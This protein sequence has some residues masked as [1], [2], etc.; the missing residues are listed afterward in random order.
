MND[1]PY[2][3]LDAET[4]GVDPYTDRIVQLTLIEYPSGETFTSLV[5]PGRPIP[6]EVTKIH[7]ITDE[8]VKDAPPF[9]DLAPMVQ[10]VVGAGVPVTFNGRRFDTPLIDAELQ[11]A[12]QPGL[13]RDGTGRIVHP[14]IDIYQVLIRTE[15]RTLEAVY[16]RFVGKPL[17]GAHSSDADTAALPDLLEAICEAFNLDPQDAE[18]LSSITRPEDEID[19]A[20]RFRKDENGTPVFNFG[21]HKDQPVK[22]HLEYIEWMLGKDFPPETKAVGRTL[23]EHYRSRGRA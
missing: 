13:P 4:T 9:R 11:R 2:V 23:L 21:K 10:N 16:E 22:D 18:L 20:G 3:F 17:E 14:E 7:G 8:D 1:R 15:P 6:A 5:N 12:G 19:R